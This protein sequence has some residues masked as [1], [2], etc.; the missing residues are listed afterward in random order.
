MR[1]AC[2]KLVRDRIPGIEQ[3]GRRAVT[4]VLD[5]DGF[6]AALLAK[7]VEEA[8]EARAAPASDLLPELAD[9][10]EMLQA[11]VVAM[12]MTWDGL[13][14]AAAGKRAVRGGVPRR[15]VTGRRGGWQVGHPG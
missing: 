8:D 3:D 9:V 2:N 1:T 15:A 6:R 4:W 7:L 14:A 10:L 11:L 13:V 12:G 5:D